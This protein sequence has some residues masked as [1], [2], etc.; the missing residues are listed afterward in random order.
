MNIVAPPSLICFI[1]LFF[2]I[3]G[4]LK[5]QQGNAQVTIKT[6]AVCEMCIQN[7]EKA[8]KIKGV[9]KSE[10]DLKTQLVLVSFNPMQT[11]PEKIKRAISKAGYDADELKAN[12][13]AY[14][15]LKKC[16]KKES[17]HP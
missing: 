15:K 2:G 3:T 9:E 7:I 16:C 14:K 8:L 4:N 13:K 11:S 10:V 1:Y 5:A 17:I 6:S 12:P